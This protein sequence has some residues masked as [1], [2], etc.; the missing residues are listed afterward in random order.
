MPLGND[1]IPG[2]G[3]PQQNGSKPSFFF[4]A[5]PS[6]ISM[7]QRPK[8]KKRA[9]EE[10]VVE[11]ETPTSTGL[12][13]TGKKTKVAGASDAAPDT[14]G[15]EE[16]GN[17]QQSE[18]TAEVEDISEEVERRLKL[19]EERRQKRK[20]TKQQK[21]K[22]ESSGGPPAKRKKKGKPPGRRRPPPAET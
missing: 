10:D 18:P 16:P 2:S 9:R 15:S 11:T 22:R 14:H 6:Q 3:K 19:R 5:E 12:I 13:R 8:S 17:T 20:E 4:D 21:R 7:P 1:E